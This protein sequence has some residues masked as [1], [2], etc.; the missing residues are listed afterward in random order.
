LLKRYPD[1]PVA[2]EALFVLGSNQPKYWKQAIAQ[3]HHPSHPG[4]RSLLVETK[5]QSATI[6]AA[7]G[8]NAYDQP[9]ITSVL[10]QLVSQYAAQLKPEDGR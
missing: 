4:N 3:F 9:G 10:D 5:S 8:K 6:A 1:H 7:I 2:A